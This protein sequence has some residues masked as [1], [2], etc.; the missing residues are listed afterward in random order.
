MSEETLLLM[1]TEFFVAQTNKEEES[2]IDT[3]RWELIE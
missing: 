2:L 1:E 3:E